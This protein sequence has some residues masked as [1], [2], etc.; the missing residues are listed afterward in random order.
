[1]MNLKD[2]N[3]LIAAWG[4]E[5]T[6]ETHMHQIMYL[7]LKKVFPK[8]Q[9]FDI[10]KHY[11]QSGK[12]NM[13]QSL[14]KKVGEQK[15]EVIIFGLDNDEVSIQTF[16]KLT[17]KYPETHFILLICDDDTR[18]DIWSRYL[19]LF[20]DGIIQS[21]PMQKD[22]KK[23]GINYSYFH[24]DYNTHKLKPMNIQKIYDVTFI[25]R[26]KADRYEIIKFL[27]DAG[28][29]VGLFGFGWHEYPDL[30]DI[31]QGSLSQEDYAKIINQSKISLN[32]SKAGFA[33]EVSKKKKENQNHFNMKGRFFEVAL[34]KAFQ[35]IEDYPG[36]EKFFKDGKEIATF[37]TKEDL[38]EKIKYYIKYEKELERLA[39][40][41][42][43]KTITKFNRVKDLERIFTKVLSKKPRKKSLPRTSE[44]I[45]T[46]SEEDLSSN[47]ETLKHKISEADYIDFSIGKNKKSKYKNILQTYSLQKTKK[48]VSC[49]DYYVHSDNLGDYL[50]F[51]T[52]FAF[53]RLKEKANSLIDL[54]QLL[55]KKDFFL[56]NI[57]NFK[58]LFL[59]KETNLLNEE[60]TAIVAFPLIQLYDYKEIEYEDM[61][62]AFEMKFINQLFSLVY[63]KK[64]LKDK[65]A[66]IFTIRSLF[67]ERLLLKYLIETIKSKSNWDKL[68]V[69]KDYTDKSIL[70]RFSD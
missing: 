34:C 69:N 24:F 14:I 43:K 63:Q 12:E 52:Y 36:L 57:N 23:D 55:V 16:I 31:Y 49:C 46:L 21:P 32:F 56:E 51:F 61:K 20:F 70:K 66:Y 13:N 65:Y 29:K 22:Y 60:N 54:N 2:K 5:N 45:I 9:S 15:P 10:K 33:E 6:Q 4:C 68:K 44:K 25:G 11:L 38:L 47:T 58:D 30:K 3:V 40:N 67:G 50:L 64:I 41:S 35:I 42:Y 17:T 39:K 62:K 59:N 37:K 28:I 18:F 1:M 48:P 27:K 19:A 8:L 53:K 7:T 26:P